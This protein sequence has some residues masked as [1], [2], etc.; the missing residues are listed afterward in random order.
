MALEFEPSIMPFLFFESECDPL[1]FQDTLVSYLDANKGEFPQIMKEFA[2]PHSPTFLH[3]FRAFITHCRQ[4]TQGV[5][6]SEV[7]DMKFFYKRVIGPIFKATRLG[8]SEALEKMGAQ[9]CA[10]EKTDQPEVP[11]PPKT[12]EPV[13]PVV[14][15]PR[16][17]KVAP[18]SAGGAVPSSPNDRSANT[19]YL[20][21]LLPGVN[22]DLN[23]IC[24]ILKELKFPHDLIQSITRVRPMQRGLN[25][26]CFLVGP[27]DNQQWADQMI[28]A[29]WQSDIRYSN[30]HMDFAR[31]KPRMPDSPSRLGKVEKLSA[32]FT[33]IAL[34]G[35][36]P[37]PPPRSSPPSPDGSP[38]SKS[39]QSGGGENRKRGFEVQEG[40]QRLAFE[41]EGD[42]MLLSPDKPKL[43]LP[44]TNPTPGPVRKH[45][46]SVQGG[47]GGDSKP[48][49]MEVEGKTPKKGPGGEEGETLEETDQTDFDDSQPSQTPPN[50]GGE[51]AKEDRTMPN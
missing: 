17:V 13:R 26:A 18:P 24:L 11:L 23:K 38:S 46:E 36:S 45:K 35:V 39:V 37:P 10:T 34:G 15:P 42:N 5:G 44:N 25:N 43:K 27:A 21:R 29:K 40:K 33:E 19:I 7:E 22:S 14:P 4:P 3:L 47:G 20:S 31:S 12:A 48:K 8:A 9:L 1:A 51:K 2:K 28:A 6:G 30:I 16:H 49:P 32:L 41:E 50:V